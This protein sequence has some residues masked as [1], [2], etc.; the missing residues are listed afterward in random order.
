MYFQIHVPGT[1]RAHKIDSLYRVSY[2]VTDTAWACVRVICDSV[3]AENTPH[4][5]KA[6]FKIIHEAQNDASSRSIESL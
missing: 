4:Q 2:K 5:R 1:Q 3:V 6:Y